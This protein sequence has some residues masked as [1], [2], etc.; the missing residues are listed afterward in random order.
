MTETPVE[1][2]PSTPDGQGT[3]I[4]PALEN[5]PL[6]C[7]QD[8]AW[9]AREI[10]SLRARLAHPTW[11]QIFR[12]PSPTETGPTGW[13]QDF[14]LFLAWIATAFLVGFGTAIVAFRAIG[15]AG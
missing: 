10:G 13:G 7:R 12:Q 4:G 1:N 8:P 6:R 15:I 14:R 9:A 2:L 3:I 11:R 5:L